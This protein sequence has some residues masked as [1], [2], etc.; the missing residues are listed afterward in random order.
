MNITTFNFY[1]T[2]SNSKYFKGSNFQTA[3]QSNRIN[4][5]EKENLTPIE[6][7]I[8][9]IKD[10]ILENKKADKISSIDNKLK[11]GEELTKE[12]IEYLKKENP[13]LYDEFVEIKKEREKY[14]KELE[15]CRTKEDVEKL[16]NDK[17]QEFNF[18]L[19]SIERSGL[20]QTQKKESFE[21]LQRRFMGIFSEHNKFTE[22]EKYQELPKEKSNYTE[23]R[24]TQ[25]ENLIGITID[26]KV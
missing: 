6:R 20:S 26:Y 5:K 25:N 19:T 12:E 18:K 9:D 1:S 22:S 24:K 17:M 7:E 10:K 8:Q 14:K 2:I 23:N 3:F 13:E 4:K 11:S 21:K 15:Q 16:R